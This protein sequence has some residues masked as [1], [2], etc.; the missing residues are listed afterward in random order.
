MDRDGLEIS[1]QAGRLVESER[2]AGRHTWK[3]KDLLDVEL[4]EPLDD[5]LT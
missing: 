2:S 1:N 5:V 4:L 3:S